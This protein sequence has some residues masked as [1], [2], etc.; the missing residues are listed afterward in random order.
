MKEYI[1]NAIIGNKELKASITDK[2]EIIRIRYPNI[3]FREFIE[4]LH[5]GVKVNDSGIIYLHNDVN[6]VYKQGYIENTNILKTEIKNTY[7]NLKMEQTDFVTNSNNVIV[8]KYVFTNEHDIPLDIKFLVHSKLLTDENNCTA[9][10]V[11]QDGILQ[12]SHGY[13]MAILSDSLKMNGYKINGADEAIG[14]GVLQDKD[15]IG[16]SNNVAVSYE[17]GILKP[18][19]T[20]E[21]YIE[22]FIFDNKEINSLDDIESEIIKIRKLELKKE[23]ERTKKYWRNYVKAHTIH[24]ISTDTLYKEK[25]NK[26]YK[27]T[28]LLY[29]LLTNEKTGGVSAAMEI[30]E[31]FSKCRKV[32]I[33]LA[34]G[35][36]VYYKSTR[37]DKDDKG[38]RK[39]L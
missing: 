39:V 2:G 5:V 29:P 19:E 26:I 16:M 22:F 28:I 24:M 21:F 32:S 9:A 12:Y 27:R 30:D 17:V 6:N 34:K 15:Y 4:F 38:D 36:C 25:I 11:I 37:F 33:L 8:C 14:S 31:T 13:N 18:G 35:C 20:K 1:N 3:D 10:K 23:L 7:F